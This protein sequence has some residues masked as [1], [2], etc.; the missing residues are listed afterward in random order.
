MHACMRLC[1]TAIDDAFAYD[2][3]I[4]HACA[5]FYLIKLCYNMLNLT[6]LIKYYAYKS[7][8]L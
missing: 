7:I 3:D 4:Y 5:L 2:N 8:F 1:F 6:K